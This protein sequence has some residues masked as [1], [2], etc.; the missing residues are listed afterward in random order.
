VGLDSGRHQSN[1]EIAWFIVGYDP[2]PGG[3]TLVPRKVV[4][5]KLD[6]SVKSLI[7]GSLPR[8]RTEIGGEKPE[9]LSK[10]SILSTQ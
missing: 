6:A 2:K 1:V 5:T 10:S 8:F 7:G 3:W 4:F 9:P